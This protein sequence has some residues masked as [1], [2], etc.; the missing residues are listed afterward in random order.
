MINRLTFLKLFPAGTAL[1]A[2]PA[3][4]LDFFETQK[5]HLKETLIYENALSNPSDIKD[6]RLE[7]EAKLTF[8]NG[9]LQM[10]NAIDPEK[11]QKSNYVLWCN[12]IFPKNIAIT[13]KFKPLSEPGLAM[14]FFAAQG[15]NGK[16]LFDKSLAKR[17]GEYPQYNHGDMNA[18]HL[19]YF[20][21][22]YETERAFHLCNLRKSYGAHIVAQGADPIPSVSDLMYP[23]EMKVIKYKNQISFFINNLPILNYL[24]DGKTFGSPLNEGYVG[25]RQMAPLIA[26]YW[27]LKVFQLS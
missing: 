14:I 12:Q 15:K 10:Q 1:L 17:E 21:R 11:G 27:D 24:D 25:F 19:A 6:F 5:E 4:S 8:E 26:A 16:D 18:F 23:M 13:W 2:K 7:G 22:R 20:R 3:V 9:R